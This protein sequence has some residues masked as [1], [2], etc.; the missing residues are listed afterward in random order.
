M[1]IAQAHAP[2]GYDLAVHCKFKVTWLFQGRVL[3]PERDDK[4]ITDL[5][6]FV[7][8]QVRH[9]IYNR[10]GLVLLIVGAHRIK[11]GRKIVGQ[12]KAR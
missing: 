4:S 1:G 8:H 12:E 9:N 5:R 3:R 10:H 11:V 7:R 6:W 2:S